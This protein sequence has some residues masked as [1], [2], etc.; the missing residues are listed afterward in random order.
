MKYAFIQAQLDAYPVR[1]LCRA[2]QVSPSGYYAWRSRPESG[3]AEANR[4]LLK[5]I[6]EIH[7]TSDQTYGYP[8]V[9]AELRAREHACGRHRVARLMQREGLEGRAPRR[10]VRT[11]DSNHTHPIAPNLL[12]RQFAVNGMAINRAWVSDLTYVPTH[13]GWLYLAVVLCRPA[14]LL[15]RQ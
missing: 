10:F 11:T 14:G 15:G 9:H 3:R 5:E 4:A 7:E 1:W 6:V 12:Q 2:L 13:Q 8:R